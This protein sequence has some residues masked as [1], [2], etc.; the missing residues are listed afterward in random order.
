MTDIV[1]LF[2][3][4]AD[5]KRWTSIIGNANIQNYMMQQTDL[6]DAVNVLCI[7]LPTVNPVLESGYWSRHNE[8]ME[9]MLLRRYDIDLFDISD[10]VI[11]N[12]LF[13]LCQELDEFLQEV[14]SCAKSIDAKSIA[15]QYVLNIKSQNTGAILCTIN[16]ESW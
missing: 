9:I 5:L 12:Q 8:R 7:D 13:P 6:N 1:A 10:E 15:Y 16:Y 11:G 3:E 14:L 4:K 2:K